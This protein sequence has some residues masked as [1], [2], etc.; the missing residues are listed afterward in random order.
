MQSN[1]AEHQQQRGHVLLIAGDSAV[2]RRTV[3]VEPSVNLAAL[4]VIPV[5]VLL[6]SQVPADTTYLDGVRDINTLLTRLRTAAAT[7]GPLL[8]YLSGRLTVDRRAQQLHL[9]LPGTTTPT[10]RYTALPL[11]WLG[12]EL[13]NRPS[14]H[15]TV[16]FDVV[17]DKGAWTLLQ[18]Y[19]TLPASPSADIFGVIAPP[20]FSAPSGLS[21]YTRAW[22]DQLR[23]N[24]DR[25]ANSRL[26]ALAT[27]AAPL[28]PGSI[29]L[30]STA[31][32][33]Q[34]PAQ[35]RPPMTTVQRLLAGESGI[36]PRRRR[37]AL[38][39][40][41]RAD[42]IP[43]DEAVG[44]NS[45]PS[46]AHHQ[47]SEQTH[48]PA[49]APHPH[50]Q[51]QEQAP[52]PSQPV[53][54]APP[55]PYAAPTRPAPAQPLATAAS[56]P[57]VQAHV[58]RQTAPVQQ[59]S[60]APRQEQDPR[61]YIHGLAQARRFGEAMNLAQAWETHALQTY[62]V[63]S[64]QATQWIE[65]RADLAKMSGNTLLATQLWI[66]AARTRLA[67]QAPDAPE[68]L[69]AARSAHHCWEQITDPAAGRSTG[70]ELINLIRQLPALDAR[71]LPA[72]QR[73]LEYLN[74]TPSSR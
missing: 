7:S 8:I 50:H 58:P 25:P 68:V 59:P 6:G 31:E 44:Y 12:A 1:G 9:A 4:A 54:Q 23:N 19:G 5:P 15:T 73:R 70:V 2:R 11:D 41:R 13:H 26:H 48:H 61:P 64:P 66:A 36:L 38:P 57:A 33:G 55:Q 16:V 45:L 22:I 14:G 32:I 52:P 42:E 30:P 53:V 43:W 62:G 18:E 34:R 21:P 28:P 46:A 27:A 3:Q 74:S 69:D 56:A 49:R 72:A 60:E 10:A 17:A 37:P 67:H 51:V 24:P 20:A 47:R 40:P 63:H 71:H 35:P 65:I 29:V 39:S